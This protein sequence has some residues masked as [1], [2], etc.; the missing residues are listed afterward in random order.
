MIEKLVESTY[1][2]GTSILIQKE[3]DDTYTW[4]VDGKNYMTTEYL[5]QPSSTNDTA[6]KELNKNLFDSSTVLLGGIGWGHTAQS[7]K[8]Y[9]HTV[10]VVEINQE[11]A[12]FYN[13]T[14]KDSSEIAD[15]FIV[16]DLYDKIDSSTNEYDAILLE[17]DYIK[18][19]GE[20]AS[21]LCTDTNT[22]LYTLEFYSKLHNALKQDGYLLIVLEDNGGNYVIENLKSAGFKVWWQSEGVEDDTRYMH[23]HC[24]AS[25]E[26]WN[27]CGHRWGL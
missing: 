5:I 17:I 16:G 10:D 25:D 27:N 21:I 6:A 20:P 4:L 7:L 1:P 12:D 26:A 9:G 24:Y 2:D 8:R 3:E 23:L 18:S 22:R 14:F 19:N 15:N 13:D 11:V